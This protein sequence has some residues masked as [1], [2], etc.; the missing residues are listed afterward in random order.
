MNSNINTLNNKIINCKFSNQNLMEMNFS[1]QKF[2]CIVCLDVLEHIKNIKK[3]IKEF[4]RILKSNKYLIISEPTESILYKF[5]RYILKGTYSKEI[6]P[7]AEVHYYNAYEIEKIICSSGFN[8]IY[9]KKIPFYF[10][11]DLFHINLYKKL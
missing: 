5:S 7:G 4:K 6:G 11:F 2:D 8:L 3:S 1:N 10:P 9:S